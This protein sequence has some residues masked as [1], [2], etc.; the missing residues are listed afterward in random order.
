MLMVWD[1]VGSP[2]SS[3]V[4]GRALP[5]LKP[6]SLQRPHGHVVRLQPP[7]GY[8]LLEKQHQAQFLSLLSFPATPSPFSLGWRPGPPWVSLSV[9]FSRVSLLHL[10]WHTCLLCHQSCLS[11]FPSIWRDG[12]GS[13]WR[14]W[15]FSPPWTRLP[16]QASCCHV[17]ESLYL[18]PTFL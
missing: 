1:I 17:I 12:P 18:S 2:F 15:L 13:H 7:T 10:H 4:W 11:F 14:C 9:C 8:R 3:R 16:R 6:S 5:R